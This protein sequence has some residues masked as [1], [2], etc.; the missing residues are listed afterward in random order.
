MVSFSFNRSKSAA[1]AVRAPPSGPAGRRLYAIGDVHGRLDLLTP[2]LEKID[3]D[4]RTRPS[5]EHLLVFLG[6]LIDRGPDS[7][8]VV[9]LVRKDPIANA[10]IVR[11]K[12]NHEDCLVRGLRGE[13]KVLSDW[14]GFGGYEC[15]QSYGVEIGALFGREPEEIEPIIA[16]A[17]PPAHIDFLDSFIDSARFG[18]YLLVHAGIRPGVPLEQQSPQDMRWIRSEFLQS[19]I[20]PGFVVVHGHSIT[21]DVDERPNRICIDTGAYRSGLLTAIWI[22]GA[23]R[24]YIQ[25]RGQGMLENA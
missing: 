12:G 11:L 4:I 5:G 25:V 23:A 17:I 7:R 15:A 14:L 21:T 1:S 10:R 20:D 8:A 22:E 24:G 3:A 6:D 9:E 13:P 16:Q 19:E 2:L 18:D